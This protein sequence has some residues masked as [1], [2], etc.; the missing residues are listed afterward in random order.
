MLGTVLLG[1]IACSG[2]NEEPGGGVVDKE[3]V[4]SNAWKG[5]AVA[6]RLEIPALQRDADGVYFNV[7]EADISPKSSQNCINFCIEYDSATCHSKWVAFTFDDTTKVKEVSRSGQWHA[8]AKIPAA[9]RLTEQGY[10]GYQRGHLCASADRL[11]S[12]EAN[13]QTFLMSNMSP[14][15]G[16]FNT[17]Y[18][19]VL[20]GLVQR[21]GRTGG[22][23]KLYVCKG[24]TITSAQTLATIKHANVN[25]KRV[26]VVV[27][28]Y[29]FMAILAETVNSSYQAIGFLMEHKDYG[30]SGNNYP[31][32]AAMK[33]YAMSIDKLESITGIDFFCNLKDAAETLVEK[34]YS[35]SAWTWKEQ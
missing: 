12:T 34:S 9:C 2:D 27:P 13:Q 7:Y 32:V 10:A 23:K 21:W 28:R 31:S 6:M 30:Y 5:S 16:D 24:G 33:K 20:E 18:W 11:N 19:V 29:Y 3:N 4:N 25:G 8:D 14:M 17:N 1:I 15:Q 26:D 22:F 35:E